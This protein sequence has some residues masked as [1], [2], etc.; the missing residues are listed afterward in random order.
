MKRSETTLYNRLMKLCAEEDKTAKFF[1]KD[2]TTSMGTDV[3]VFSYH[4][5]SYSDWL[6][7]GAIECRGI[8]FEMLDGKP[9][10]IMA[11][12]MEKFFNY[13]E[14]PITMGLDLNQIEFFMQK[15]D[16]SLVSTYYDNGY[17]F[18]KSKTSLHSDQ[19]VGA[20]ALLNSTPDY[21]VLRERVLELAAAGFTCNFEYVGP[22]NR[23]VLP[24]DTTKLV[25]L[26]VR[27]NITGEYVDMDM[28][29][30]D[31]ALRPFMVSVFE[32]PEDPIKWVSDVR[33]MTGIEGYVIKMPDKYF[34]LKTNWYVSMHH[35]KDSINSNE[36]LFEAIA[37]SCSDDLRGMFVD[38]LQALDKIADF[39]EAFFKAIELEY[40]L[41][42]STVTQLAGKDR[43]AFAASAQEVLAKADARHLFGIVMHQFVGINHEDVIQCVQALFLKN[44]KN[45]VPKKYQ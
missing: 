31:A 12:P 16:G 30:K 40:A 45:Y 11:R 23:I 17:V 37:N 5:A 41:V 13:M 32:A 29:F 1:F 7:P 20:S 21:T 34:K 10:R 28:L 26:N 33:E 18:L 4:I 27:D 2:Q 22:Y 36:R 9:V 39:E 43:K 38:D 24:Y 14:N 8:M 42:I 25:L 3:R 6:L 44:Y 15:E 35:T 19:A